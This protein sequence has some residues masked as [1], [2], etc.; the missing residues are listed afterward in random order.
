[1]K[2]S[3]PHLDAVANIE[4][5]IQ[6]EQSKIV[7]DDSID[8]R[9]RIEIILSLEKIRRSILPLMNRTIQ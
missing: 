9:A 1:M 7:E 5:F 3:N 8:P 4:L 2:T 6:H